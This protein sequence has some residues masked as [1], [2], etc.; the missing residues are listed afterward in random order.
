M[1]EGDWILNIKY[2]KCIR[3]VLF[4]WVE[5]PQTPAL[6]LEA[7]EATELKVR[8]EG[9]SWWLLWV[10]WRKCW[11][12]RLL[13]VDA[14]WHMVLTTWEEAI[15]FKQLLCSLLASSLRQRLHIWRPWSGQ[16]NRA[17]A[18]YLLQALRFGFVGFFL[19]LFVGFLVLV[20]FF[21]S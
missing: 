15:L 20:F 6:L 4:E 2:V 3:M 1:R 16:N 5:M 11:W 8:G 10:V 21:F 14:F 7:T 9:Y 13:T 19:L 12:V 18:V 17:V